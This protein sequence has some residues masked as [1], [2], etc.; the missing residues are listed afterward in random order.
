MDNGKILLCDLSKGALGEDV[1]SLLGSLIVTKLSL[2]ALSRQDAK[3][4]V[5]EFAAS[6]EGPQTVEQ[7]FDVIIPASQT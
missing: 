2:A 6:G 4:L 5:R 1:T 7:Q 3:T